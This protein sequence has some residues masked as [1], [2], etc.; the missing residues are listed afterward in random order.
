M[1]I[2]DKLDLLRAGAG[3]A[4]AA[5]EGDAPTGAKGFVASREKETVTEKQIDLN[6]GVSDAE[7]L[8]T[9]FVSGA[10]Q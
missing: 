6:R 1:D 7:R 3:A 9:F 2:L 10:K 4:D 8:T 5:L